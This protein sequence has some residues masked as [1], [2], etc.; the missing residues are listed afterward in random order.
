MKI[1]GQRVHVA[2]NASL[3]GEVWKLSSLPSNPEAYMAEAFHDSN[4]QC[5]KYQLLK[6][7]FNEQDIDDT[8]GRLQDP[9]IYDEG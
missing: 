5:F 6:Q 1:E 9:N 2:L 4:K 8:F 3:R 7:G